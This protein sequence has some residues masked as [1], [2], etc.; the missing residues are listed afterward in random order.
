MIKGDGRVY[1]RTP[2]W[3]LTDGVD[4]SQGPLALVVGRKGLIDHH[5]LTFVRGFFCMAG[6]PVRRAVLG[7]PLASL[8]SSRAGCELG[9]N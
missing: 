7:L 6:V 1:P 9:R 5:D 2:S 3:Y 8:P 4:F